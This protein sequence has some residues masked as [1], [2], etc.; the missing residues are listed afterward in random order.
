MPTG[1]FLFYYSL[2]TKALKNIFYL[3]SYME[4]DNS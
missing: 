1:K 3:N 2:F 4:V